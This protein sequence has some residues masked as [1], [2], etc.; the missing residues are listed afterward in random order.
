MKTTGLTEIRQEL[1]GLTAA[2]LR[3]LCLRLARYRVENKELLGYL[4]FEAHDEAGYIRA[5]KAEAEELFTGMNRQHVYFAKKSVRKILRMLNRHIRYSGRKDTEA[6]LLLFFC[7]QMRETGLP[8]D[9]ASVLGR[10]YERQLQKARAALKGLHEDLQHDY[11]MELE[12]L[13]RPEAENRII[14]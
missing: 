7:R 14:R 8:L 13:A 3:E 4:L 1:Q 11:G 6:E 9:G 2:R 12:A 5:V 10:I